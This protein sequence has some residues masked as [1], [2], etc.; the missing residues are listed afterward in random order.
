[1]Y[2]TYNSNV[3]SGLGGGEFEAF[4]EKSVRMAFIRKVYGIVCCQ[5]IVTMAFVVGFSSSDGARLWADKHDWLVWVALGGALVSLISLACCGLHRTFP[6]NMICLGIFTLAESLILGLT[7]A[8]KS[9]DIVLYAVIVTTVIVIALTLF[10]FQTKIDFTL[11][12]GIM[13]VVLLVFVIFGFI[14]LYFPGRKMVIVYS[15]LG[16]L[17]FSCYLVIDTQMIVGGNHKVQFSPEDYVLA[18]ITIYTDIINIFV[19]V[20]QFLDMLSRD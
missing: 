4:S 11:Y 18:A 6:T 20:L 17:I 5:L 14:M 13:F 1:M 15:G 9:G 8:R 10:A 3:E 7:S 19:Y 12:S 2:N 16:T